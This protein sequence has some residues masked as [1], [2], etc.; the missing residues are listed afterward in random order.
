MTSLAGLRWLFPTALYRAAG[1]SEGLQDV[2][3]AHGHPGARDWPVLD[4]PASRALD[5]WLRPLLPAGF[6]C[7]R[8]EDYGT[9]PE[10]AA[11]VRYRSPRG[12]YVRVLRRRLSR[13]LLL[14]ALCDPYRDG[15]VRIRPTGTDVL[16]RDDDVADTHRLVMVRP[17][18]TLLVMESIG[19]P[20][21]GTAAPLSNMQLDQLACTLDN[22][23]SDVNVDQADAPAALATSCESIAEIHNQPVALNEHNGAE[24]SAR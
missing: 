17:N 9:P 16:R 11:T 5:A 20:A 4:G 7:C 18:G 23:G 10:R 12:G 19:I 22:P 2:R 1:L 3:V 24:G 21:A 6:V 14:D 13:P 8:R 15:S